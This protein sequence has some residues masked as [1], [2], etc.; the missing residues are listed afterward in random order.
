MTAGRALGLTRS[1]AARFSFLLAVPGIGA[2]GAYEGL[3]LVTSPDPVQWLPMLVGVVFAAVSGIACIHF[4][5][6]FIERI[7]LLP[8]TVYRLILASVIVWHFT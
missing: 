5:I 4:L 2:A 3:K 8:F 1:A 7:G 6:R